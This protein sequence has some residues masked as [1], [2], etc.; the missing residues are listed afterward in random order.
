MKKNK[1]ETIGI[2]L[3]KLLWPTMRKKCSSG[4]EKLLKNEAEGQVFA[5][6]LKS[7]EQS[8]QTVKGQNNFL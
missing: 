6:F 2:L 5:K 3:P 8:I 4:Q 1:L 7:P